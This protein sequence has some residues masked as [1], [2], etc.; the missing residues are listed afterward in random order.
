MTEKLYLCLEGE[1]KY[2]IHSRSEVDAAIKDVEENDDVE[3]L[4]GV[5]GSLPSPIVN[6]LF[7]VV[8]TAGSPLMRHEIIEANDMYEAQ[9]KLFNIKKF[10]DKTITL[11]R[12][13]DLSPLITEFHQ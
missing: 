1:G 10:K 5:L 9:G 12:M 8:F 2:S 4:Y 7:A 3:M 6:K 11:L 13:I